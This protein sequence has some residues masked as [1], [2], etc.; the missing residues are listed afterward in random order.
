MRTVEQSKD[1]IRQTLSKSKE[2]AQH[3]FDPLPMRPM[4]KT[5]HRRSGSKDTTAYSPYVINM[6]SV[7]V[8]QLDT[9]S[10]RTTLDQFEQTYLEFNEFLKECPEGMDK[11]LAFKRFKEL[12]FISKLQTQGKLQ[13]GKKKNPTSILNSGKK[14]FR[15]F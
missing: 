9:V 2:R 4:E 11:E 5:P 3:K 10:A 12:N 1:Q 13:D 8:E 6:N 15:K 7:T 14:G